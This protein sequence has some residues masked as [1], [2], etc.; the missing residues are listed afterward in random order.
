MSRPP[1]QPPGP[2]HGA[3]GSTTPGG[4]ESLAAAEISLAPGPPLDPKVASSDSGPPKSATEKLKVVGGLAALCA[5]LVALV[6]LAGA[7]LFH[8]KGEYAT[9]A[10]TAAISAMA[11]MVG[12]YFGIKIGTD[13]TQQAH[14]NTKAAIGAQ[15]QAAAEASAMALVID[16]KD[17]DKALEALK[18]FASTAW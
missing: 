16:P 13:G 18:Q 3:A 9:S 5:G 14:E 6:L 12:A 11:T 15:K 17:M 1:E 2:G 7:A 10:V 8:L 4:S